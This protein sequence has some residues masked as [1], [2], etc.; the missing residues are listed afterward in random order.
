MGGVADHCNAAG[1]CV[2]G[3]VRVE[4]RCAVVVEEMMCHVCDELFIDASETLDELMNLRRRRGGELPVSQNGI[5][6]AKVLLRM[7]DTA[8]IRAN[9]DV[10]TLCLTLAAAVE[11]L[12]GLE[13]SGIPT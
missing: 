5:Q 9:I 4:S 11:R 3:V 12:T 10:Q 13:E 6:T 7:I 2:R 8:V 1:K